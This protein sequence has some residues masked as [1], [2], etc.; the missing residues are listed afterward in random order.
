M[1][2]LNLTLRRGTTNKTVVVRLASG[3]GLTAALGVTGTGMVG[4]YYREGATG[5]VDLSFFTTGT[6]GTFSTGA[7]NEI[8]NSSSTGMYAYCLPNASLS[9]TSS[10]N[11]V[12]FWIHSGSGAAL[13]DIHIKTLLTEIDFLNSANAG[14][15]SIPS[16]T[17]GGLLGLPLNGLQIPSSAAGLTSGI[18]VVGL[19]IPTGTAGATS[20]LPVVGVQLGTATMGMTGGIPAVGIQ[21]PTASAGVTGGLAQLG[22]QI[23]TSAF[24]VFGGLI[25]LGVQIPTASFGS[26][27]GLIT[28]TTYVGIS[29][30]ATAA[31]NSIADFFLDRDMSTGTDSGSPTVRTPRQALRILRN[32]VLVT[33]GGTITVFK[34]D[35]VSTSW[36][37][38]VSTNTAAVQIVGVDPA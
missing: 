24:G 17:A 21:L 19:Q 3:V 37:G 35:D 32:K 18:A 9:T 30:I 26:A 5:G 23:P 25:V 6:L 15:T 11:M 10:T 1:A 2:D 16:V 33:T 12:N 13:V 7:W 4:A 28:A 22:V 34:E 20:G 36:T 38:L 29:A 27:G 31:A 8:S 14:M